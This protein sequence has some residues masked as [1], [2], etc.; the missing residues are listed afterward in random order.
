VLFGLA[1]LLAVYYLV[2]ADLHGARPWV[3]LLIELIPCCARAGHAHGQRTR[4]FVDVLC[5]ESVFHQG[6]TGGL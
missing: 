6:R 4:A 2:F 5:G 1:G 3:I